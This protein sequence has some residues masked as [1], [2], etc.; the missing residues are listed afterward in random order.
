MSHELRTPLNS[1]L[2]LTQ[3]LAANKD[4][5]LSDKQIEYA[6]TIYNSGADLL[7]LINEILDLSKVE[8][9]KI[10]IQPEPVEFAKLTESLR[11]K[12][13]HV[14]E[15]KGVTFEIR[16]GDALLAT[17]HTDPQR[18]RQ[19]IINL[20]SN[21]FK[22]TE[23]GQV[24]LEIFRPAAS[25]KL[26][27][28]GLE[29]A[30][31]VAFRVTDSG[32]G[33]PADKQKVIFEAFQQAD[34][35]TNRKYGGTGLGLSISRQLVRLL[36]G[37][38]ELISEP[39][40]GSVFTVFLPDAFRGKA[41]PVLGAESEIP[42][43]PRARHVESTPLPLMPSQQAVA[44]SPA[45]PVL[46]DD[47]ESLQSGEKSLLIIED[48][49]DFAKLLMELAREKGFK[50]LRAADG[51]NGLELARQY[52]PGAVILDIGL[53]QVDGWT[54]MEH[55]KEDSRTR[56]IPVHFVSGSDYSHGARQMGAIGYSMK[57]VNMSE[58]SDA[59]NKIEGFL[60]RGA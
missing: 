24:I 45:P 58:L 37:D 4:D 28:S 17:I 9:G 19:I 51:H 14:A 32:I 46:E 35:T 31:S 16:M 11:Q 34:G 55:I 36:G 56:H 60:K 57:P 49:V 54:V 13:A 22:F 21:A 3:L 53:P 30:S 59:F 12:F 6:S 26:T 43:P 50:C 40:K 2:I 18:L 15:D 48:D 8:A 29:P 25:D 10:E 47:R 52:K 44:P 5:N 38:I 1:L 20:L 41:A 39:G 33:I 42:A 23:Q 27:Q 7:N